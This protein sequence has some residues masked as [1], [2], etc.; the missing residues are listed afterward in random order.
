MY[1]EIKVLQYAAF[2]YEN[3]RVRVYSK[4]VG[5]SRAVR[6]SKALT[7]QL[8]IRWVNDVSR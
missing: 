6:E 3:L 1:L 2:L 5:Y 8:F 7:T 4:Y